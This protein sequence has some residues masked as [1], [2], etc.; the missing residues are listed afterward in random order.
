MTEA[1]KNVALMAILKGISILI[2]FILVPVTIDYVDA[3]TYGIW[4]TLSSM[5][6]WDMYP[7]PFPKP[8]IF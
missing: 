6:A 4:L 2:S 8:Y 1:M 3:N 7:P 5:I